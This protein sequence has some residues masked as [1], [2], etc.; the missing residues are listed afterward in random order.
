MINNELLL[1][2]K[3]QRA[4]VEQLKDKALAEAL[5]KNKREEIL[6]AQAEIDK[7]LQEEMQSLNKQA[8]E[9]I[10]RI[11]QEL[12]EALEFAKS[13]AEER[14]KEVNDM[15]VSQVTDIYETMYAEELEAHDTRIAELE[16]T[17]KE[18]VEEE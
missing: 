13:S 7:E 4:E 17:L 5:A 2:K 15:N 8:N 6:P 3:K 10:S 14:K 16:D 11:R 1:L 9:E 18:D 12:A